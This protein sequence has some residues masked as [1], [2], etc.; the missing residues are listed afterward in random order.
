MLDGQR[1]L[2]VK[3]CA[4]NFNTFE[5]TENHAGVKKYRTNLPTSTKG[6]F[7]VTCHKRGRQQKGGDEPKNG[8]KDCGLTSSMALRGSDGPLPSGGGGPL[9]PQGRP[10]VRGTLGRIPPPVSEIRTRRPGDRRSYDRG[11]G[12]ENTQSPLRETLTHNF[13]WTKTHQV[14]GTDDIG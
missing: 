4:Q 1:K 2:L 9:Q 8:G 13:G 12:E 14:R 10:R 7:R 3:N 11:S 6:V 5:A